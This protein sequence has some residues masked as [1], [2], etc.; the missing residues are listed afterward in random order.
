MLYEANRQADPRRGVGD[1]DDELCIRNVT[2][3]KTCKTIIRNFR[4]DPAASYIIFLL[5]EGRLLR[6][7]PGETPT[8]VDVLI[9]RAQSFPELKCALLKRLRAGVIFEFIER[10]YLNGRIIFNDA[11]PSD[12]D[13]LERME[14]DA[15]DEYILY[16]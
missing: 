2:G 13:K 1:I 14:L 8:E 15:V 16:G 4:K 10:A 11:E 3:V 5:D 7:L 9:G 12:Q 6:R